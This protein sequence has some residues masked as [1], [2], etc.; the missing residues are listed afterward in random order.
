MAACG[1]VRDFGMVV[2]VLWGARWWW[3]MYFVINGLGTNLND[4]VRS[5]NSRGKC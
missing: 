5:P 1:G 4:S 3:W 2:E